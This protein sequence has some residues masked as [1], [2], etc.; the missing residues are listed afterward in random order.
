M[1]C[2]AFE[3]RLLDYADLGAAER[4]AVD[5][6]TLHCAGCREYL[7][8]L[9]E[10]DTQLTHLFGESRPSHDLA[11]GAFARARASKP[12]VIPELL[13]FVGWSAVAVILSALAWRWRVPVT[14]PDTVLFYVPYAAALAAIIAGLWIGFRSWVELRD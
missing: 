8:T 14:L 5:V 7:A 1:P 4:Q 9:T 6:H 2:V 12:T 11:A 13:D 10:L 3:E